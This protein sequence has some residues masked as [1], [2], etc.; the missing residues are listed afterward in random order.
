MLSLAIFGGTR[1]DG[2]E[3]EAGERIVGVALFGGLEV[4]FTLVPAPP[5][6]EMT[7][8]SVFGTVSV[9][10]RPRQPV[11][12]LGFS[13]FGGR[14]VDVRRPLPPAHSNAPADTGVD[15]DDALPIEIQAYALFGGIN[16]ERSDGADDSAA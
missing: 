16:V 7:L 3:I 11:R 1:I 6:I 4:D 12:L 2:S 9:K 14:S 8:V 5:A 13:V 10:V 15:D